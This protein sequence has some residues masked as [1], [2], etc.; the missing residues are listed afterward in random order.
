VL[1]IASAFLA[2]CGYDILQAT[3]GA[4]ALEICGKRDS[5]IH[6]LLTDVTMPKM[7]GPQLAGRLQLLYPEIRVL[8]MSGYRDDQFEQYSPIRQEWF[9]QKPFGPDALVALVRQALDEP[10]N[11]EPSRQGLEVDVQKL[12][13]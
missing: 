5:G 10:R 3:S 13:G 7:T 11:R 2:R 4:H 9:L 1:S 8:Y 12:S 6:L